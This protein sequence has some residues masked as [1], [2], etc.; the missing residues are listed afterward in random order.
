MENNTGQKTW[1]P[2]RAVTIDDTVFAWETALD[3]IAIARRR[4]EESVNKAINQFLIGGVVLCVV[5][6]IWRFA[7]LKLA[8]YTV[9]V[10]WIGSSVQGMLLS[11]AGL[12]STVVFYR[13]V[14]I[15]RKECRMPKRK[16][17]DVRPEVIS[18]KQGDI[19]D[20]GELLSADAK[21][22]V[23]DAYTL[24]MKFGH[25]RIDPIHLFIGSL[26][27]G[28]VSVVFARLGIEFKQVKDALGRRLAT[29]EKSEHTHLSSEAE[30]VLLETF[31]ESMVHGRDD[32]SALEIFA[33]AYKKSRFLQDLLY[34]Y[35]ADDRRLNNMIVWLRQTEIM[36]ERYARFKKAA[37]RKPTGPMNRAMTSV[38]TPVLDAFAIDLTAEAVKGNLPMLVGREEIVEN[39]F[40]VI[41]GGRQSALLVGQDGVGKTAIISGIAQLMVE[42]DVPDTLKDK[43]LVSVSLPH[44]LSGT[45]PEGASQRLLH[46]LADVM[47][48]RNII[49]VFEDIEQLIEV[50]A[51]GEQ[52]KD[53]A[54]LLIEYLNSGTTFAF[55]TTNQKAFTRVIEPSVL[56][57]VFQKVLLDEPDQDLAIQIIQSHIPY[58]EYEHKVVF[59]Y[60]AVEKA[61]QLSDRYMHGVYLP[62]KALEVCKEAALEVSKTHVDHVSVGGEDVARIVSAKSG[63]PVTKVA[64]EEKEVLLNLEEE[65]HKRVIGQNEAVKAVSAALKRSR[66]DL[67][68][69][70]RPV[71]NFLFLGPTGVGKTELAKAIAETYFG[72]EGQMIR[73]DMSEYQE[74]NSVARLIGAPGSS[75]GGVLTEA[76]RKQPFAIVLLDELEKA[77]PDILN[78]FLQVFDDGRLTDVAGQTIDFTNTIIVATSNAGTEMI[79]AGVQEGRALEDIKEHLINEE[80]KGT[81]RPE[82]LNRFDGVIVFK[83]LAMEEMVQIT[84]I[85]MDRLATKL[86]PKG[87]GFK[88]EEGVVE[89]LAEKGYDPAF[90]ARPL[91]RVIQEEVDNKIANI[92]LEGELS[93]RDTLVLKKGGDI[94]IERADLL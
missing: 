58:L 74:Q 47:R 23:E 28:S 64:E 69:H 85:M 78:L 37:T 67:S 34:E 33:Q 93:R 70:N 72:S 18:W 51:E 90:G 59:S 16:T 22:A 75:Q 17:T 12:L 81:Y 56:F 40:R 83:P 8:G 66:A 26:S 7:L 9:S 35:G 79:Q 62:H 89:E 38:A 60:E 42:E 49:L 52:V 15:R 4:F 2:T 20:I 46:L 21:R 11:L 91:R 87:Y 54:A 14:S 25:A 88:L 36:K 94:S 92:I 29:Q 30:E 44:L 71:A 45:S 39:M 31:I 63:I 55:A 10:F 24:A 48:A 86:E 53:L 1:S 82:F 80:L 32:L 68:S 84:K 27:A 65:I 5:G 57:R 77:H 73:L 43:R 3:D 19:E 76:V 41:E 6:V 50:H 61:V 13:I